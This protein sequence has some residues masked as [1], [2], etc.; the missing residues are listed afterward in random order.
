MTYSVKEKPSP[1]V[2]QE[3]VCD[4]RELA[5]RLE[6][7]ADAD[8]EYWSFADNGDRD[9]LHSLFRYPAMMVP[10]LQRKL[11]ETCISWDPRI[12]RIYDPFVGSGTVMTESMMLGR[13]FVG[14]DINPLAI[15]VCRAKSEYLSAEEIHKDLKRLLK[16]IE[17]DSS[18]E[19]DVEFAHMNKWFQPKV[20]KGICRIRRAILRC[21]NGQ[22]RR[23]WWVVLA[24]TI[25]LVSNSRTS[26]VKL[27]LR[28]SSEIETRPDSIL[29]FREIAERSVRIMRAQQEILEVGG[30]LKDGIYERMIELEVADVRTHSITPA[31]LLMSS[32]PYG[33]NHSTVTYGQA[34]YLPLQLIPTTDIGPAIDPALSAS[35]HATDTASLGGISSV[36]AVRDAAEVIER[37]AELRTLIDSLKDQPLDRST[38]VA[39]FFRDFDF[40]LNSI[41]D[42]LRP[43][44][45]ML[46]TVGDRSVGGK[47]VP[48]AAIMNQ[49]IGDRA[50]Y[51]TELSRVIPAAKKRMPTR[52]ALTK[53]MGSETILVLRKVD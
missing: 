29:R 43:G 39:G 20:L 45:V 14:A 12:D 19:V 35:T 49:L 23:F 46:W 3:G 42:N 11:L 53:T 51:V 37:S 52:N 28:P 17:S 32:P 9:Y 36:K 22:T 44:A 21:S 6:Q 24:E 16:R 27:H 7:L 31:D 41:I 34:A 1:S 25:R 5:S 8:T 38:R 18:D 50:T 4:I 30:L 47:R 40:G 33:D 26:T 2:A 48:M 15:L 10:R 13:S